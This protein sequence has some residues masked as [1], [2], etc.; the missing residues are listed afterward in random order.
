[1]NTRSIVDRMFLQAGIEPH[2]AAK[3]DVG[4][5]IIPLFGVDKIAC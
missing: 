4:A 2:I 1:V 3:A 5:A